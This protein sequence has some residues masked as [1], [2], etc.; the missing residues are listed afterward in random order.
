MYWLFGVSAGEYKKNTYN[1]ILRTSEW[2]IKETLLY[3][4]AFGFL[5]GMIA[6]ELPSDE[7][8]NKSEGCEDARNNEKSF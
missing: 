6:G 1:R 8:E 5:F 3:F 4:V 2:R 7:V